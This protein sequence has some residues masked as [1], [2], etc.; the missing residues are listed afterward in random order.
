MPEGSGMTNAPD[1][2][3]VTNIHNQ[4]RRDTRRFVEAVRIATPD[5]RA[6]RLGPLVRWARGFGHEL[7]LHHPLEDNLFFPA[8]AERV[9]GVVGVLDGL[10]ADHETVARLLEEWG[11]AAEGLTDTTVPFA[12]ARSRMLE[13]AITLRD[14]LSRH[15]DVEDDEVWP[16]FS[17]HYTAEEY[18]ALHARAVK[19]LPK[20]GLGFSVPWNVFAQDEAIR[21]RMIDT[22][23]LA[24]R[25]LFRLTKG[26]YLRLVAAAF[27]DVPDIPFVPKPVVYTGS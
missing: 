3:E 6:A 26:R 19:Y 12:E 15:L 25:V 17:I 20:T 8:L 10:E 2:T 5:E 16:L 7:H 14:L 23:P 1:I 13:M 21:A 9:P 22:A 24:L 11:P 18:E 27:A 4:M